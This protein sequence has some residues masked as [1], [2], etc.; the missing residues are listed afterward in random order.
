[1]ADDAVSDDDI[2]DFLGDTTKPDP[3]PKQPM[4]VPI[5]ALKGPSE[6]PPPREVKFR[7]QPKLATDEELLQHFQMA[8]P[9]IIERQE[10]SL[11]LLKSIE[12]N[13]RL[14]EEHS[15]RMVW[16][17]ITVPAIFAVLYFLWTLVRVGMEQ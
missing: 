12:K 16:A 17:F 4:A 9:V 13:A 8:M 15:R 10:A 3:R 6:A 14:I 7:D 2:L 11:Q 5:D 1:M